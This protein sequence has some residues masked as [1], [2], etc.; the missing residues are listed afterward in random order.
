LLRVGDPGRRR[1]GVAPDGPGRAR[2]YVHGVLSPAET[3]LL[4]ALKSALAD[5]FGDRLLGLKLFGSRARGE[6]RDDSDLDVLVDV[7]D[8]TS[9][10]RA[11]ILDLAHDLSLEHDLVLS[12][13]VLRPGVTPRP[14]IL[15]EA[16]AL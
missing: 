5:R 15:R 14:D 8:V 13:L 7:R 12:P 3:N 9:S 2:C 6:G 16:V 10:E 11:A 4:V 1:S